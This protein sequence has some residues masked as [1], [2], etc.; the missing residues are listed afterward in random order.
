MQLSKGGVLRSFS[1]G[2]T[3]VMLQNLNLTEL[4]LNWQVFKN[5]AKQ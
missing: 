4:K 3:N 5:L 2:L 1:H